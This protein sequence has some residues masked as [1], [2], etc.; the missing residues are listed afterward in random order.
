MEQLSEQLLNDQ[1]V[2]AQFY[3]HTVWQPYPGS[4]EALLWSRNDDWLKLRLCW[5]SSTTTSTCLPGRRST[6]L[7]SPP[8]K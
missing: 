3:L 7:L 8:V 4:C 6:Q 1:W 5:L 2:A